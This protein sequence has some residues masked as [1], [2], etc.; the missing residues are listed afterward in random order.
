MNDREIQTIIDRV[1]RE[2]GGGSSNPSPPQSAKAG[3]PGPRPS[4]GSLWLLPLVAEAIDACMSRKEA[5]IRMGIS[6][7]LLSRQ[8]ARARTQHAVNLVSKGLALL[9]AEAQR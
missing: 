5:A 3:N 8:L 2:I 4:A 9:V 6:E 1:M 7:P